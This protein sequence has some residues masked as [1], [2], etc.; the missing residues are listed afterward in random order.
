[1]ALWFS[2][3]T[4]VPFRLFAGNVSVKWMKAELLQLNEVKEEWLNYV[5]DK[6]DPK[7]KMYFSV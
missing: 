4:R 7:S 6:I 2:F 1:M 5:N 3:K